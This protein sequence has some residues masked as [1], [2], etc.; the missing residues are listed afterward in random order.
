MSRILSSD[1]LW[2]CGQ[3][4]VSGGGDDWVMVG[5]YSSEKLAV[6]QCED[7][8]YFVAPISLDGIPDDSCDW[9]GYYR[10]MTN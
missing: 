8:T 9:V 6:D 1:I 3:H 4:Q 7:F 10:P 2:V 5:I